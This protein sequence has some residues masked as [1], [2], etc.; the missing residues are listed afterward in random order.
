MWYVNYRNTGL[1]DVEIPVI[2]F[3]LPGAT[4]LN[5]EPTGQHLGEIIQFLGLPKGSLG[6]LAR[7]GMPRRVTLELGDG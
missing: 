6:M 2:S 3:R 4:F 7:L 1:T 5:T